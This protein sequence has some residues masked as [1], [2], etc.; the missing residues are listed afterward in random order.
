MRTH[1][2]FYI[3]AVRAH[4][5]CCFSGNMEGKNPKI[6]IKD[7]AELAK[8][9]VG[10]VD[11]VLHNRGGVSKEKLETVIKIINE[12]DYTPNL[13]AKS[14]ALKKNIRV[15]ILIPEPYDSNNLYWDKPLEG[16]SQAIDELHDYNVEIRILR[17]NTL[18]RKSFVDQSEIILNNNFDGII[19][20]P[21]YHKQSLQ[22]L[23]RCNEKKIPV[24]FIDSTLE[25]VDVISY[26]GQNAVQSGYLAAKLMSFAIQN[27]SKVLILNM[28]N[29][30]AIT[31]HLKKREKG[32]L[33]FIDNEDTSGKMKALCVEIDTGKNREPDRSL[34]KIFSDH[35]DIK[36][37]FVT[38]ARVHQVAKFIRENSYSD[39]F[40]GGYD[41]VGENSQYLKDGIID[42]LICQ[43]PEDQGYKSTMAMFNYLM[44][45]V[46]VNRINYSPIDIVLK[47]NVDFYMNA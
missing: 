31:Q 35:P 26:F 20:A 42:F 39:L 43:R 7:I 4:K 38:N 19:F 9:S 24:I 2:F 18:D 40:L 17:F 27:R 36:G 8:V 13:L 6:R 10:T 45:K 34:T 32:F 3:F 25:D 28:A 37:V 33:N 12:L 11:R 23:K 30:R 15:A 21:S 14:L 5:K 1:L 22:F 47:E 46:P 16:I 41:L 44:T 29:K